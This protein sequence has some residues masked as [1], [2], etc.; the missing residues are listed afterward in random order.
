M[1]TA[2]RRVRPAL[3]ALEDRLLLSTV[4]GILY[5]DRAGDGA[6]DAG[7]PGLAGRVVF[8]DD[9]RDGAPD[10]GE[11]RTTPTAGGYY[12]FP[13]LA[14]GRYVVAHLPPAGWHA[15]APTFTAALSS[16]PDAGAII[17]MD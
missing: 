3:E 16:V 2:T 14:A 10:A 5:D 9:N 15:T 12:S 7:E 17:G 6:R 11:R 1:K 4:Q 8:L 13:G